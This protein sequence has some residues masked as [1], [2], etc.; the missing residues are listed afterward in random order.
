LLAEYK[1]KHGNSLKVL[2]ISVGSGKVV[3]TAFIK[4]REWIKV[5]EQNFFGIVNL[6]FDFMPLLKKSKDPSIVIVGSIAGIE[7]IGAPVS[8]AS[9]KAALHSYAK[10]LSVEVA[11]DGVR[12]NIVHPGNVY[13]DG[14]RWEELLKGNTKKVRQYI[15]EKVPMRRFGKPK[16][17]AEAILFLASQKA[18]FITGASLVV[19][20]GQHNSF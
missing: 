8:Y 7:H 11:K 3:K 6:I 16:D 5:F 4:E 15:K 2:V 19:D 1:K 9:A 13:F 20:G 12:V 17:I 10:H 14:G 18:E